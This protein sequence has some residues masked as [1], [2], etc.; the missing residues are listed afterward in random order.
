MGEFF[1]G[2][3]R[4]AGVVTLVMALAFLGVWARSFRKVD[5]LVLAFGEIS[6][7]LGSKRGNLEIMRHRK[8]DIG[9]LFTASKKLVGILKN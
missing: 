7:K 5:N 3:R 6:W 2:W 8:F 9:P 4:K 1:K